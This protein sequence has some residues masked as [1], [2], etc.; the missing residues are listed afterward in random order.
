VV[1]RRSGH[2]KIRRIDHCGTS[3][4][5]A[6]AYQE[7]AEKWGQTAFFADDDSEE[8]KGYSGEKGVSPH[9]SAT[10]QRLSRIAALNPSL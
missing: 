9:F 8:T 1:E 5:A 2:P 6:I 4:V 3:A 7:V 10:S